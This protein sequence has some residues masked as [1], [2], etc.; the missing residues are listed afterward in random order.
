MGDVANCMHRSRQ[1]PCGRER[2]GVSVCRLRSFFGRAAGKE[3]ATKNR[4]G[5]MPVLYALSWYALSCGGRSPHHHGEP[6]PGANHPALLIP[7]SR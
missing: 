4:W 5:K 7:P 6:T 3:I 1:G 2:F